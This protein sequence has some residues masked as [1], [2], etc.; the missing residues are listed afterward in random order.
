MRFGVTFSILFWG[1]VIVT[2]FLFR[3]WFEFA[4]VVNSVAYFCWFCFWFG[5]YCL[6]C[7]FIVSSCLRFVYCI[8][9]WLFAC[10]VCLFYDADWLLG[11]ILVVML[12]CLLSCCLWISALV[13]LLCW[14]MVSL[15]F[16]VYERW[17]FVLIVLFGFSFF[18]VLLVVGLLVAVADYWFYV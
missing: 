17:D 5:T 4:L 2:L 8:S 1:T 9:C 18:I 13:S 10:L 15:C 3:Y 14:L 16:V 11:V 6:L 12:I 7:W